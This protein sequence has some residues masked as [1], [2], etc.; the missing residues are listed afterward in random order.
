MGNRQL[1]Q[2]FLSAGSKSQ[3]HLATVRFAARASDKTLGLKPVRQFN[4]AVMLNLQTFGQ[5]TDG[6]HVVSGQ[7]LYHQ[8]CLMLVRLNAGSTRGLFAE[9][10]EAADFVAEISKRR[11]ID[12]SPS[13]GCLSHGALIIS[14]YDI[15][16]WRISKKFLRLQ[17]R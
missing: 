9:V 16:V 5:H 12:P 1:L 8:Q 17:V 6:G 11:V 7:S 13:L 3:Q 14:Y 15:I 2:Q 10:Q 4:C